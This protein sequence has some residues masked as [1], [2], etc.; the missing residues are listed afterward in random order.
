MRE[1]GVAAYEATEVRFRQGG[2]QEIPLSKMEAIEPPSGDQVGW[3]EP[4]RLHVSRCRW[5][6]PTRGDRGEIGRG[7]GLP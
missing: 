5:G 1:R 6:G 3:L 7:G 2:Q 4:E